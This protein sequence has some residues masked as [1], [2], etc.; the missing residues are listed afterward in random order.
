MYGPYHLTNNENV[1]FALYANLLGDIKNRIRQAYV[2][3]TLSDNVE[4]N[5]DIDSFLPQPVANLLS[6]YELT[7]T[8]PEN[9]RSSLP[10]IGE[11]ETELSRIH[12]EKSGEE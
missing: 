8:R 7:C 12:Q 9:L 6:E 4:I 5:Q 11:L 3:A 1:V 10:G 2:K